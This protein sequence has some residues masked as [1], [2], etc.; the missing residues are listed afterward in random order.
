[1]ISRRFVVVF[2]FACKCDQHDFLH[3][4]LS[5]FDHGFSYNDHF[6]IVYD[7]S[8]DDIDDSAACWRCRALGPVRWFELGWADGLCGGLHLLVGEPVLLSVCVASNREIATATNTIVDEMVSF[9]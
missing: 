8:E 1:M 5:Y 6:R 3:E 4:H 7:D 2:H 9:Q